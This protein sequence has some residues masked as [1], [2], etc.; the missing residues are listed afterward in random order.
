[1]MPVGISEEDPA[2]ALS[3]KGSQLNLEGREGAGVEQPV[4]ISAP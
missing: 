1:M 2:W 4:L 3:S